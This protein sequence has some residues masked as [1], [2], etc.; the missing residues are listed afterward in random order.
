L[1]PDGIFSIHYPPRAKSSVL[2]QAVGMSNLAAKS[3]PEFICNEPWGRMK[4]QSSSLEMCSEFLWLLAVAYLP[5]FAA[6]E[7]EQRVVSVLH[8]SPRSP[9]STVY[10][11]PSAEGLHLIRVSSRYCRGPTARWGPGLTATPAKLGGSG[12]PGDAAPGRHDHVLDC[13]RNSKRKRAASHPLR[14]DVWCMAQVQECSRTE[15]CT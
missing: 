2:Q 11:V 12:A 3:I 8:A 5:H 7:R 6:R 9:V 10:S 14:Y 15:A 13:L 4:L 1:N